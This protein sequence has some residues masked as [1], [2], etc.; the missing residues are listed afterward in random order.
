MEK[1]TLPSQHQIGDSVWFNLWS[2]SIP[3]EVHAVH[4][5]ASKVKYDL[6]VVP[7]K[8]DTTRIYNVDSVFISK[9][10][11]DHKEG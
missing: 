1:M 8:G 5:S 7:N 3:A 10:H 11:P 9:I 6:N 4:F 2:N